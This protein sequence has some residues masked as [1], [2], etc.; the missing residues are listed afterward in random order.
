MMSS[1]I[2]TALCVTI[3]AYVLNFFE[4]KS[5]YPLANPAAWFQTRMSKQIEFFTTG[6]EIV[7]QAK[8]EFGNKPFRLIG[9]QGEILVLPPQY[10][11]TIRNEKDLSFTKAI[12]R[13]SCTNR[14]H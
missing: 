6:V 2:T 13:V 4:E 11:N 9:E 12:T 14:I 7:A 5:K 10:A 3:I 8:K 1:I